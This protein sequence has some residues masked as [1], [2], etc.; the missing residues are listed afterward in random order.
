LTANSNTPIQSTGAKM[1]AESTAVARR[2]L[3]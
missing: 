2:H 3:L 1:A